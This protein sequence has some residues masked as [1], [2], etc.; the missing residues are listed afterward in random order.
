MKDLLI[1]LDKFY[2]TVD[3]IVIDTQLVQDS[4]LSMDTNKWKV[5]IK[6][7]VTLG[8]QLSLSSEVPPKLKLKLLPSTLEYA[9]LG[10][11]NTLPIIILS[12]LDDN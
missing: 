5:R 1:Q 9:F 12:S 11:E 3:F 7:L 6:Q 8:K 2:F 4:L 10:K